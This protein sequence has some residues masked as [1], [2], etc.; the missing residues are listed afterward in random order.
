M[1]T[2][3]PSTLATTLPLLLTKPLFP[4]PAGAGV[5]GRTTVVW[6]RS[7]LRLHDH[8]ALAR[9]VEEAT[10]CEGGAAILPVYI[11]DSRAFGK[12]DFGF[13]KTG[14]YRA[15]FLVESVAA[16]R[17]ALR[18]RGSDLIV[19]VGRADELL[20]AICR[21]ARASAVLTHVEVTADDAVDDE[22]VARALAA[23]GV[24]LHPLWANT[25]YDADDL[26]FGVDS[27][28]DG[29]A[30][31]REA[32]QTRCEVRPPLPA[33]TRMPP[34]PARSV[35]AGEVPTLA[36]LGLTEPTTFSSSPDAPSIS[37]S[38][39]ASASTSPLAFKGGEAEGLARISAYVRD[40][41]DMSDDQSASVHL[42]TDFTCKISPWL[43]VGCVSPRQIYWQLVE[44]GC[45]AA[46]S[47][48]YF[49]LVWRDFFRFVTAKCNKAERS[50]RHAA[51]T[52]A[53]PIQKMHSRG[54]ASSSISS[55][56]NSSSNNSSGRR[57]YSR[58]LVAGGL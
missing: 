21:A 57:R 43:L 1:A 15:K 28:P 52:I 35:L 27:L 25:L 9:A 10:S 8:P 45:K 38:A 13:E 40:W 37:T 39:S 56:S 18:A 11:F 49:E 46:V 22:R 19:R 58:T 26:P 29:Y 6:F 5:A 3:A 44:S 20:P 47:T 55:N 12:T 50:R 53:D 51:C 4:S 16:L 2:A 17:A 42:S 32:V 30:T 24:E 23:A 54:N 33:P 34:L 48:T 7:D 14:R 31:F 41:H 36:Q